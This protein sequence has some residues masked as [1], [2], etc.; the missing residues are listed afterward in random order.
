[1]DDTGVSGGS[2]RPL[3]PLIDSNL[4]E[5]VPIDSDIEEDNMALEALEREAHELEEQVENTANFLISPIKSSDER[6]IES[7]H[8][9]DTKRWKKVKSV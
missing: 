6:T 2:M 3:E 1:M 8:I 7:L 9:Q 5:T 4:E